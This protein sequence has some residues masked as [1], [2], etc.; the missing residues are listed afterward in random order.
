MRGLG[1]LFAAGL[2]LAASPARPQPA[3]R[4]LASSEPSATQQVLALRERL[5]AAIARKDERTIE[6]IYADNFQHLRDSGRVD[7]KPERIAIVL[8]GEPTIETAPEDGLAVHVFAPN[9][10]VATGLSPI[11]DRATGK[12]VSFR[13]LALYVKGDEGWQLALSQASRVAPRR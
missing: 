6:A 12:P 1:I 10:A 4:A 11:K 5:R 8:S 3:P 13:W 9:A 7:L 2:V